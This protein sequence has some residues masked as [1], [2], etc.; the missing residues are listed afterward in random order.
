M[1]LKVPFLFTTQ[2]RDTLKTWTPMKSTGKKSP[3]EALWVEERF[4]H[5]WEFKDKY[6][7]EP[8]T[9]D[10]K[11]SMYTQIFNQVDIKL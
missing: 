3:V 8:L 10:L 9:H 6:I 2:T 7:H 5:S 4:F 11:F 1:F